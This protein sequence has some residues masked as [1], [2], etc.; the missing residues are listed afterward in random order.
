MVERRRLEG[1]AAGNPKRAPSPKKRAAEER[2]I[3]DTKAAAERE[4]GR[5]AKATMH[6]LANEFEAA[7]GG[8]VETVFV[9]LDRARGRGEC[10]PPRRPDTTLQYRRRRGLGVGGSLRQCSIGCLRQPREMTSS[11]GEIGRQVQASSRIAGQA[12]KQA[13]ATDVRIAENCPRPPGASAMS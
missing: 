8:I 1:R 6:K 11:I 3:A 9:G 13:E 2:E 4:A 7:V 5:P 12:V 10:A